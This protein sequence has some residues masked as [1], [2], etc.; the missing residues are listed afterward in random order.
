MPA[1][2]LIYRKLLK[3][4]FAVLY[5]NKTAVGEQF[6]AGDVRLIIRNQT[7]FLKIQRF[8]FLL[9]KLSLG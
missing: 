3:M 2:F 9:W 6:P 5:T 8:S 7:V 1:L 4:N